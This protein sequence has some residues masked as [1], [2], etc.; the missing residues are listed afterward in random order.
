MAADHT[1]SIAGRLIGP[2]R[3]AS[4]IGKGGMGEVYLAHDPRLGRRIALK[5]LSPELTLHAEGVRRFQQEART[6]SALNHPNILTIYEVGQ[7]GALQFIATEFV[8]GV[9][10]REHMTRARL[11]LQE[12]LDVTTQIA[13]ALVAAHAAGIVHRDIK[14][15]NIMIRHD[16]L[17]KVLD[18]GIAKLIEHD[19]CSDREA[20]TRMMIN[21]SPGMMIGTVSYMSPEQARGLPVDARADIWSLGVMLYEMLAG[22]RPFEGATMSHIIVAILEHEP[23]PLGK[24]SP[25]VPVEIQS[26]VLRSLAKD[27]DERYQTMSEMLSHLRSAKENLYLAARFKAGAATVVSANA[28]TPVKPLTE[29]PQAQSDVAG[30]SVSRRQRARTGIDSLAVLPLVNASADPNMEYLSDCITENI[31]NNFAQIPKL[32]V[33]PRNTVFR[34]KDREVD[35]QE[36]GQALNVRAV[37]TGRVRQ[38]GD[39]LIVG[40]ELVDVASDSQLWGEQFNREV[41]DIFKIQ[42]E[43]ASEIIEKLRLKLNDTEKKRLTKRHTAKTESY[44][45]YLKG[46]FYWNKRTEDALKKAIDFFRQAIEVDPTYALAY[47][48]IA[49]CYGILNFF[50][51]LSPKE[52]ATKATAAARKALEIDDTLAEVHTSVGLVKLIYDWEW[53]SAEREFKR[54]IKLSPNYA[55]AHDWYSAYLMAVGKIDDAIQEIK[56]AQ[57]LDPLSPIITT[58]LARQFYFA[59]QPERAIHECLR[60]LEMEPKLAPAHWFPGQAF[61]CRPAMKE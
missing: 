19:A 61:V 13:S 56:H 53:Q 39:R 29:S 42:E 22:R 58:G 40:V 23:M 10:L 3:I 46:R 7:E 47:A 32:R 14:P 5:L 37:L 38:L 35:P 30:R 49:D 48:G 54:A 26:I 55:T 33:V 27:K 17:I 24:L 8:E 60:I 36:I 4:L 31:I 9:T 51:D 28:A 1:E 43:I 15:D 11:D 44:Q 2:Y 16:G 45:L 57:E 18:F 6:A 34:Y 20:P 12:V 52:S 41:T 25:D 59:R 21:T 50:G